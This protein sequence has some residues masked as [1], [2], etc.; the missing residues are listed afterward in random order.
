[1]PYDV[2]GDLGGAGVREA[3]VECRSRGSVP[4]SRRTVRRYLTKLVDYNPL[5]TEGA[6]SARAYRQI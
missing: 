5:Q 2:I 4:H 1:M 3:V 6:T